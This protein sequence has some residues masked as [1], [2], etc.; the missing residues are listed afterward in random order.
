MDIV[1]IVIFGKKRAEL[2]SFLKKE[3]FCISY[4]DNPDE[5]KKKL[6]KEEVAILLVEESAYTPLLYRLLLN[7]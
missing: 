1:S 2:D 6:L 5:L 7:N 4:T 3:G